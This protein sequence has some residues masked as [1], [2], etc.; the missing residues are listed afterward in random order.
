MLNRIF[1]RLAVMSL[2]VMGAGCGG[3]ELEDVQT[4]AMDSVA[5]A[6]EEETP[7]KVEDMIGALDRDENVL[8]AQEGQEGTVLEQLKAQPTGKGTY[9][10]KDE[11]SGETWTY[12]LKPVPV[13]SWPFLFKLCSN[14]QW[15][16]YNQICP[17]KIY[18]G[19]L[20]RIWINSSCGYR[21]QYASS[22]VCTNVSGGSYN[23]EYQEVWKC[24]VGRG[25]CVER[26][27]ITA[28]RKNYGVSGC[29]ASFITSVQG[30]NTNYRCR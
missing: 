22:S 10:T 20:I 12:A 14:G 24:G 1:G 16:R 4:G 15:V 7:R 17:T 23:T 18:S 11:L 6:A 2:L 27:A 9:V 28:I 26:P 21:V 8:Y 13:Q 25:I 29:N 30:L 5:Q 19:L 3:T